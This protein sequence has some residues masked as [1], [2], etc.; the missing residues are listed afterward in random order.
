MSF[1]DYV[2]YELAHG[3]LRPTRVAHSLLPVSTRRNIEAWKSTVVYGQNVSNAGVKNEFGSVLEKLSTEDV[4]Q[5]RSILLQ[6]PSSRTPRAQAER[7]VTNALNN[8]M[9]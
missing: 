9:P 7:D 6:E 4:R 5:L 8:M 3:R 1:N 2:R